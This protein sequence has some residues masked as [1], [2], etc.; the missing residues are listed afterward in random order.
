MKKAKELLRKLEELFPLKKGGGRH[1]LVY[2]IGEEKLILGL[3]LGLEIFPFTL[4][5]DDL[6]LTTEALIK[7][8]RGLINETA[9]CSNCGK[10]LRSLEGALEIPT[11]LVSE[12]RICPD[13]KGL[14]RWGMP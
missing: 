13:S 12:N 8:I 11:H 2:M 10:G 6:K 9:I 5:E 4:S 1:S 14:A 7:E 3:R